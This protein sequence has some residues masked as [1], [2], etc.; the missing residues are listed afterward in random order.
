MTCCREHRMPAP[1]VG[2]FHNEHVL[3]RKNRVLYECKGGSDNGWRCGACL[4]GKLGVKPRS[5]KRCGVCGA[6]VVLTVR[7]RAAHDPR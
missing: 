6:E 3:V 4:R 7:D 2:R 5:G 1:F